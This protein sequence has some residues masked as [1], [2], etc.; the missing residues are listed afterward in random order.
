[1]FFV[2]KFTRNLL[3][4]VIWCIIE[5]YLYHIDVMNEAEIQLDIQNKQKQLEDLK[6]KILA[7]QKT[8][9]KTKLEEDRTKLEVDIASTTDELAKLS[10]IKH[11]NI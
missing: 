4:W 5:L 9:E 7:E 6:A 2:Y 8:E 10:K 3:F 1:M 11:E